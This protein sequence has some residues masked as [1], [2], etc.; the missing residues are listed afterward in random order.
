M[1]Y[2]TKMASVARASHKKHLA[3]LIVL[4]ALQVLCTFQ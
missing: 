4:I 1:N 3:T 2:G